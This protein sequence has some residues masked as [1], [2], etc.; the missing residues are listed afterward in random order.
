MRASEVVSRPFPANAA[1]PQGPD[2]EPLLSPIM[3]VEFAIF[4]SV[5]KAMLANGVTLRSFSS[6]SMQLAI[7]ETTRGYEGFSDEY[8]GV[9]IKRADYPVF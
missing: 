8:T 1:L 2:S 9:N 7:H 3:V 6:V 5:S 4:I